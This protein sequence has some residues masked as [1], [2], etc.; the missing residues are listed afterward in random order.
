MLTKVD[1]AAILMAKLFF[2]TTW[3][4]GD[5]KSYQTVANLLLSLIETFILKN[6][7][8]FQHY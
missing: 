2:R 6:L 4:S 8:V 3:V 7:I 1:K 5:K